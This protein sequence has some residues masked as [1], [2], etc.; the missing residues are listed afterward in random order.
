ML[1]VDLMY[2]NG[3]LFDAINELAGHI[4]AVDDAMVLAA[5]Y[6]VFA[7]AALVAMS[8]FARRGAD[9]NRRVAVYTAVASALIALGITAL[10]QHFYV[11]QRP[12]IVRSDVVLLLKHGA[13]PSFPSEQSTA[14]FAMATGIG[15]YRPR[16]GA[17]LLLM[18]CLVAFARVYVGVHYP[19]DVSGGALLGISAAVFVRALRPGLAWADR[20]VVLRVVP[21]QLR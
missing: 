17:A 4:D 11:H 14:A 12:F 8:W 13:D 15:L 1:I 20:Q 7:I 10:I 19:A 3:S 2:I 5:R 21:V 9:E 18:A 6:T 16:L